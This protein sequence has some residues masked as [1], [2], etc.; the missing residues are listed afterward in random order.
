MNLAHRLNGMSQE[1]ITEPQR[2]AL[3]KIDFDH[4]AFDAIYCSHLNRTIET[5]EAL[6]ILSWI[7]DTRIA[8]RDLGVFEGLTDAECANQ[9]PE[10]YRSFKLFDADFVVPGGESRAEH[11]TRVLGWL[12]EASLRQ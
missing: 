11:L 7:T 10:A 9:Y 5:A 12:E 6:G 8:E 4:S 2:K 1:G 3:A